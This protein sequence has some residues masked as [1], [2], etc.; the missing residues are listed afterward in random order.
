MTTSTVDC[1]K[2][3]ELPLQ[4]SRSLQQCMAMFLGQTEEQTIPRTCGVGAC[5]S[6]EATLYSKLGNM[7]EVLILQL[8]RS[9]PNPR[10]GRPME[11]EVIKLG[12]AITVPVHY[13]PKARGPVYHLTGALN[14]LSE[15]ADSGHYV[16]ILRD[17]STGTFIFSDDDLPPVE[18]TSR[19]VDYALGRSY[20]FIY[21]REDRMPRSGATHDW[22]PG[23]HSNLAGGDSQARGQPHLEGGVSDSDDTIQVLQ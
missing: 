1:P 14:Q 20:M 7:P 17:V 8:M 9:V 11:P 19:Q 5:Q 13:Q 2:L 22:V 16:S 6:N 10:A 4:Q 21:S 23:G 12:H 18:M 15:G 3:L